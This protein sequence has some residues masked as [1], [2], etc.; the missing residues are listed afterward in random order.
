MA[1]MP[2]TRIGPIEGVGVLGAGTAFPP[3]TYTNEDALR[4]L[5]DAAARGPERLA[6]AAKGLTQSIGVAERA[7]AHPPGTPLAHGDEPTTLDLALEAGRAAL[8]DAGL[9]AADLGLILAATSTPHRMTSTLA[10]PLGAALGAQAACM[11]T[12]TGCSAGL[13]ALGTAALFVAAGSGP[14]LIVGT[15][16]FSKVVPPD[17]PMGLLSLGDGAGA[18]VLGRKPGSALEGLFL[19]SDGN[20]GALIGTSGPLPPTPAA[21]EAGGY[22]LSGQPEALAAALPERYLEAL[23]AALETAGRAPSDLTAYVPHQTSV[24]LI[25]EVA[26]AAG[27]PADRVWTDGVARHA[28]IGAAGWLVAFAEARAAGRFGDGDRVATA[29]VG[30]G[31]SWAAAV[32]RC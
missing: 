28:N 10:V 32:L 13:F 29:S 11:D 20:L 23:G 19:R 16:T 14:A 6:F 18:L 24:P 9:A 27:I 21:I 12:R 30:G 22:Q 31:M 2:A 3:R 5:P 4:L 1:A 25:R 7:W 17:H 8:E 15:E 26:S